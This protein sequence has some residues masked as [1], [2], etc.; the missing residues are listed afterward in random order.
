MA[1]YQ[2]NVAH[3]YGDLMNTYGD[4]GNIVALGYYAQQLDVALNTTLVS[5]EN[6]FEENKYDFVLFGGGQDYEEQVVSADLPNKAPAIKRYIEAGGPLLGVCGGFQL[7]GQYFLLADGS[8]VEG[9]HAMDHYTL[10]QPDDRFIGNIEIK[11]PTNGDIYHGFENHQGRTFLDDKE[12]PLGQVLKGHGNNGED[13]GEGLVYKNVYGTY[14]HG[15][16]FTRNGNLTLRVLETILKRRYPE[17]AW[18]DQIAK[19]E[20]EYF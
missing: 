18:A 9:I 12:R 4:Y 14:F 17:V 15:P 7:L 13:G 2:I 20:P 5:L 11:D 16:I 1:K 8:R 19:I 6:D 10:N 3:L